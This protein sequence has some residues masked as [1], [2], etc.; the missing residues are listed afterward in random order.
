[1][2][3]SLIFAGLS[4]FLL[5]ACGTASVVTEEGAEQSSSSS[6]SVPVEQAPAV[7]EAAAQSS[8]SSVAEADQVPE[9][10]ATV[11]AEGNV[12]VE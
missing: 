3:R 11:D 9:V 8:V 7:D 1:M 5:S 6:V 10:D 4:L 2:K 12:V